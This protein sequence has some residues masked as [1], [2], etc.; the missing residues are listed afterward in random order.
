MKTI[1]IR[2]VIVIIMVL[3]FC[4]SMLFTNSIRAQVNKLDEKNLEETMRNPWKP[5]R[6]VFLKEWLILGSIPI[7]S[8][9]ELDKDFLAD[10][11]GE[12]NVNP[13]DGQTV[14][15]NGNEFKWKPLNNKES[16][17]D[18]RKFFQGG[19]VE[20]AVAYAYTKVNIEKEQKVSLLV[21]S[22]DGI[23]IWVNGKLVHRYPKLR[24]LTLDEDRVEGDMKAGENSILLKIQQGAGGW[25]FAVRMLLEENQYNILSDNIEVFIDKDNTKDKT[26]SLS[27]KGNLDPEL[28]KQNIQL[29]VYT[30]GG[31]SVTKRTLN[32][33]DKIILDYK[34]WPD[35]IFEFRYTY[36]DL[37]GSKKIGYTSWYKGDIL[38]AA[39][40]LVNSIPLKD[41]NT[42][43]AITH[44]MLSDMIQIRL[45]K[46]L[47]NPDSSKLNSIHSPLMEFAELKA[48]KQIRAGGFVRL[49]YIDDIDNTPQ[50]CRSYLPIDYNASKKWPLVIYLHGYNPD[51]PE[52]YD[53]W[54]SDKRHTVI[55][56]AHNM[57]YIEPH[58]RGNT[59]YL[60]IGDRDVMKCIEMAKE[61]FNVDEDRIYLTGASM[62]GYGV[63]NIATRHPELF[64]AIAPIYGGS[65]YHVFVSKENL[66]KMTDW[67]KYLNDKSS[68]TAQMESLINMPILVS[69]GDQD[70]S[71]NVNN[72]RY[73]VRMLQ[74]WNYN[75]KYHEVPGKGHE[76][77]GLTDQIMTWFLQYKRDAN[78]KQVRVRSADLKTASAYWVNIT[79]RNNPKEFIVADAEVFVNN[80]IRIDTQNALEL[81][82]TPNENLV[83]YEKPI[84]VIWNGK[85]KTFTN[86]KEKKMILK[87]AEYKPLSQCKTPEMAG[88]IAQ[89][90]N[91]PFLIVKGTLSNDPMMRK[92]IMQ[93][94]DNIVSDWKNWQKFEPRIMND[95]EV[96]EADMKNYSL[97]LLGGPEDNE[98][99]KTIFEKIPFKMSKDAIIIDGKLFKAKDA[100]LNAVYPNPY[101]DQ[102]Y[103]QIIA[104]TSPAGFY[105]YDQ[106]RNNLAQFDYYIVDGTIP[107]YSKGIKEEKVMIASGFFDNNWKIDKAFLSEGDESIRSK[108]AM[109]IVN[110]DLTT[111][112]V[113]VSKPTLEQLN[114]YTGSYQFE[115][116]GP[117]VKVFVE[118]GLLKGQAGGM[119]IELETLSENEFSVKI[120]NGVATFIKDDKTND[121]VLEYY[122]AGREIRGNKVK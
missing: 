48:K 89:F 27:A 39:R 61:K 24:G 100:A 119:V 18:L 93:K 107:S 6:S 108:S 85:I 8:I 84:K 9:I 111:K 36:T 12:A 7:N 120:D 38:V 17:I 66:D 76:E 98:V 68:E 72:S 86:L 110:E 13:I 15:I 21:G 70:Q 20:N 117:L 73:L 114:S 50:F 88:P 14:K 4:A 5:D 46:N 58:G 122:V 53:W 71:V 55:S 74:R 2:N 63:W 60:G 121:Y 116:G 3:M 37:R 96:T 28:F 78:P 54:D 81:F 105:F 32:K 109:T 112:I 52:I 31:E 91:T 101:N 118:N 11:N 10:L 23:K 102:R 33:D 40:E 47:Q 97:L 104:G 35:G 29:D 49:A 82:L 45:G 41:I 115:G 26:L 19:R 65:D 57:I 51:N 90:Q 62:G 16:S 69:H 103:V 94:A 25:G 59:S 1:S 79:Q 106:H 22:D 95:E 75:V 56:D 64:A 99:T 87:D 113:G 83:N 43:E 42:P 80:I 30:A 34:N 92:V 77:L 44:R 67:E